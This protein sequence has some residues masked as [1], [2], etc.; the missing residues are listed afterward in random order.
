VPSIEPN[1]LLPMLGCVPL[2]ASEDVDATAAYYRERLGFEVADV[3]PGRWVRLCR[4][5][6]VVEIEKS[7]GVRRMGPFEKG[8]LVFQVVD[9]DAWCAELQRRGAEF[10]QGPMNQI[11]GRRDLSVIDPNGYRLIF[12]Q[13]LPREP[14]ADPPTRDEQRTQVEDDEMPF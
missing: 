3:S 11:Y 14:E 10:D 12:W 9:V 1:D 8:G 7:D 13:Q 4:G 5:P 2:L 6:V